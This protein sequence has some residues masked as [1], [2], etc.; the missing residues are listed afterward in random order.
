MIAHPIFDAIAQHIEKNWEFY[1]SGAGLLGLGIIVTM[2]A[3][4]PKTLDELWTWTRNAL[5]TAIPARYHAP[6]P[7]TPPAEPAQTKGK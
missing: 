7:P 1:S 3:N 6:D 5:Q 4:R 2:P